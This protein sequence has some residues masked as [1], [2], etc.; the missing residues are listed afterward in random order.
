MASVEI[1]NRWLRYRFL[2]DPI[3]SNSEVMRV[4]VITLAYVALCQDCNLQVSGVGDS[5]RVEPL[6]LRFS[7]RERT[8]CRVCDLLIVAHAKQQCEIL[9]QL[10]Q[11]YKGKEKKIVSG[12]L[13]GKNHWPKTRVF[14]TF[15]ENDTH[16]NG[17]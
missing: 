9:M 2:S 1:I 6:S 5:C 11:H 13:R 4:R 10:R 3:T 16:D 15:L 12:T 14:L 17:C 7:G 8:L